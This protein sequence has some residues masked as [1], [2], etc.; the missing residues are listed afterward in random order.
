M[1]FFEHQQRSRSRST[2]LVALFILGFLLLFLVLYGLVALIIVSDSQAPGA[3]LDLAQLWQPDA[4]IGV[5]LFLLVVVGLRTVYQL[6]QLSKGGSYVAESVGGRLVALDTTDPL[7]RRL[8]NVVQEM[9]IASGTPVPAVYIL[10]DEEGINAFAAGYTGDD[11]AVAVTRGALKVLTRDELQGVVAHEFSHIFNGDMRLNVRIIAFLSGIM[12][13]ATIGYYV[14]RF[15][16]RRGKAAAAGISA[17]VVLIVLG[18]AGTLIGKIIQSSISRQREY[19][20]DASAV[21]FTRNPS[22][23]A[24]ALKKIGGWTS[25]SAVGSP[26]AQEI[27]H[28]FFSGG[29]SGFFSSLFATHPPLEKRI[30]VLDPSFKGEFP[31]VP[32]A[33]ADTRTEAAISGLAAGGRANHVRMEASAL[34]GQVG[35]LDAAHLEYSREL[36]ASVPAELRKTLQTP[37]GAALTIYALLLDSDED[38]RKTQLEHV[39][40]ENAM[41]LAQNIARVAAQV[42]PLPARMRL[43]LLDLCVP[44]LRQMTPEQYRF[45]LGVMNTLVMADGE[46]SM[47]EFCVEQTIRRRLHHAFEKPNER[48]G[49]SKISAIA[50]PATLLLSA[51]A[52]AG[53][54]DPKEA[55]SAYKAAVQHLAIGSIPPLS[56]SGSD[57]LS[58]LAGQM[59]ALAVSAPGVRSHLLEACGVCALHDGVVTIEEA[60]MLRAIAYCLSLPLPPFIPNA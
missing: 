13:L 21:Q 26:N 54:D 39:A 49:A 40:V 15:S 38:A 34:A 50:R 55:E 35:T 23:I 52:W 58:A 17:G 44:V 31:E 22:G 19:L 42:D 37:F 3:P 14:I 46:L 57:S 48:I 5:A 53:S 45:M 4:F 25:G 6:V 60:E 2:R 7:E 16:P 33:I 9:A 56:P 11:A 43:P 47:F 36:L 32:D 30:Q 12:A 51:L 1:N 41:Q 10:A 20:A 27:S 8:V 28:M 24:G 18:A 59:D 29:V